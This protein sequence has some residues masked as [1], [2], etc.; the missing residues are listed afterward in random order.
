MKRNNLV[1]KGVVIAVILLFFSVSVI[2]STGTTNVKPTTTHA[3][4]GN[5]LYVGGN[6]TGNYSSIQDAIDDSSNGDTVY[7]YAYSSPYYENVLVDKSINLIGEDRETT[8]IDG[9]GKG[10][11]ITVKR[12]GVTIS[13]FTIQNSGTERWDYSGI[14]VFQRYYCRIFNNIIRANR[15]GIFLFCTEYC[16]VTNNIIISNEVGIIGSGARMIGECYENTISENIISNNTNYGIVCYESYYDGIFSNNTISHNDYGLEFNC[17]CYRNIC[18]RNNFSDNLVGLSS[19]PFGTVVTNNN[20]INN[21]RHAKQWF[22]SMGCLLDGGTPDCIFDG[23]YW[24]KARRFPY[25][26]PKRYGMIFFA[27]FPCF[28]LFDWHPAQEPYDI[29]V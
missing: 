2:P 18:I 22:R 16:N 19:Q 4:S 5:T 15:N 27:I 11:V 10:S 21:K 1:K 25:P 8:V 26:I 7:V 14:E 29:G 12:D 24:G 3:T 20:F 13:G 6:G 23:N 17:N 9:N 28:P